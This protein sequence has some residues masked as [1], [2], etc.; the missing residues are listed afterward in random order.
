[1]KLSRHRKSDIL[2]PVELF[3]GLQSGSGKV[4]PLDR[5]LLKSTGPAL[6][7]QEVGLVPEGTDELGTGTPAGGGTGA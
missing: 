1:M 7:A 3:L 2:A 5:G 4:Q 6:L